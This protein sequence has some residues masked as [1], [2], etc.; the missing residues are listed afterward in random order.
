[1]PGA[2]CARSLAGQ[3]KQALPAKSPRS[4][5]NHPA[6]PAQWFYDLFRALLGDRALFVTVIGGISSANLTPASG[7]QDHTTSPSASRALVSSAARVH[8]IPP[9]VRDDRDTP[10]RRDGTARDIE[11]IWVGWESNYFCDHDWTDSIRLIR[12]NKF[13][14]TRRADF[15]PKDNLGPQ[16]RY[17]SGSHRKNP[18]P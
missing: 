12:L 13:R 15:E 16:P 5:R 14:S 3:K 6:F 4:H 18:K 9:R 11:V 17:Q 2:Q 8:R 7:R 10:P 1:M